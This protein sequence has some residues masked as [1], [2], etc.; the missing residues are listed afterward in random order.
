MIVVYAFSTYGWGMQGGIMEDG[1]SPLDPTTTNQYSWPRS[2]DFETAQTSHPV[3]AGV[4]DFT[5]D[6]NEG[7]VD[8]TLDPGAV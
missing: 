3:L 4:S 8:V 2:L 6:G 5:Y 1:Y 7:Y